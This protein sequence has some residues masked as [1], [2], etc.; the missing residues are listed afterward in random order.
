[1]NNLFIS[2]VVPFVVF[3]DNSSKGYQLNVIL[4]SCE[5]GLLP[6]F[7][8]HLSECS[9]HAIPQTCDTVVSFLL[10]CFTLG[11][12]RKH[13][14]TCVHVFVFKREGGRERARE[15]TLIYIKLLPKIVASTILFL[16][17]V[18]NKTSPPILPQKHSEYLQLYE[19]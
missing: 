19:K 16:F 1:M 6:V 15:Y 2:S 9:V 5:F 18:Q 12:V 17:P 8:Y 3:Y 11:T 13:M 4:V 14:C 7:Y 10:K